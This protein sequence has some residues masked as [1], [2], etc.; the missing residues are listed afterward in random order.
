MLR[1]AYVPVTALAKAVEFDDVMMRVIFSD[2]A[3]TRCAAG[4]VSDPTESYVG[5]AEAV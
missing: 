4:M 3:G 2:G 1:R 5:A